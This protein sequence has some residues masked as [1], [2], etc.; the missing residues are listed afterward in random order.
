METWLLVAG[1]CGLLSLLLA[2]ERGNDQMRGLVI[3]LLLGPLG[4]LAMLLQKN[5]AW[6]WAQE[7][8]HASP[9]GAEG[10]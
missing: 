4:V 3:G 7:K 10:S 8:K 2:R 1:V 9:E 6:I 5:E